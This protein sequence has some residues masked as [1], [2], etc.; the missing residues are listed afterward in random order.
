[1]IN[2]IERVQKMCDKVRKKKSNFDKGSTKIYDKDSV[3]G[4]ILEVGLE[5]RS[6]YITLLL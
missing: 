2:K 3:I 4:Y 1:M 6:Q 5:Y